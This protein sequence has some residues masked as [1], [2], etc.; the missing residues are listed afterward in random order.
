MLTKPQSPQLE[1]K[2]LAVLCVLAVVLT[3]WQHRTHH[4]GQQSAPERAAQRIMWPLEAG[5]TCVLGC[6]HD[7][8]VSLIH[9]RSLAEENRKLKEEIDRLEAEKLQLHEY[10]LQNKD[11]REKLGFVI[12]GEAKGVPARAISRAS[13]PGGPKVT[14]K[15]LDGREL[16][17]G[18]MVMTQKGL[19]GRVVSAQKSVGE[20]MLLTHS[21]HA[22][23]GMVQRSRDQGMLYA[24]TPTDAGE[25]LLQMEKV[26]GQADLRVGDVILT[27]GLS[28]I[29]PANVRIGTV[30]RVQTAPASSR[31]L[32]AIIKPAANLT[33]ITYVLV[34][35]RAK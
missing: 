17:V 25:P 8:F 27:A 15:S 16:E 14:I 24:A 5:V 34:V 12:S 21:D 3:S 1:V 2:W 20:V 26:R 28:E 11:L 33:N 32:K 18:N 35:R 10:F 22:V 31:T 30:I 23:A 29:Y 13:T 4:S 19:V 9:A 6:G 7:V